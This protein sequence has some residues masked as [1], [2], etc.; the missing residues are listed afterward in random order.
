MRCGNATA[1]PFY[2]RR[3]SPLRASDPAKAKARARGDVAARPRHHAS[4]VLS[5]F[6]PLSSS[7]YLSVVSIS[8]EV[9]CDAV[10]SRS[11]WCDSHGAEWRTW[12]LHSDATAVFFSFICHR[13]IF[14]TVIY[15]LP[16]TYDI[17]LMQVF[18]FAINKIK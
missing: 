5:L 14:I 11:T 2:R 6:L 17:F 12:S 7:F 15:L 16:F 4:S 8:S 3:G 9:G 10:A 18:G 13:Y 1:T